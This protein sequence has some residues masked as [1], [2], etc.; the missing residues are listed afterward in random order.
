M[1][2]I[3]YRA[4]GERIE[5]SRIH[6]QRRRECEM[7]SDILLAKDVE[8]NKYK[9]YGKS[10]LNWNIDFQSRIMA[11]IKL[12]MVRSKL[13]VFFLSRLMGSTY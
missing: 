1:G 5:R 9:K 10:I 11:Q 2:Q 3:P 6:H 8:I 7:D 12:W 13:Y 4:P